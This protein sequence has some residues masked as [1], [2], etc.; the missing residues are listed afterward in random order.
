MENVENVENLSEE[1]THGE[2]CM[3]TM[4]EISG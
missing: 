2:L 4:R 3:M 1:W